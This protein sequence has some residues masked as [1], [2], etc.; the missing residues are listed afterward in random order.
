MY[1]ANRDAADAAQ[2]AAITANKSLVLTQQMFKASQAAA[3]D[4]QMR[5]EAIAKYFLMECV[6]KGQVSATQIIGEAHFTR[7]E[8]KKMVQNERRQLNRSLV[9]KG[10]SFAEI[11]PIGDAPLGGYDWEWMSEQHITADI[12]FSYNNGVERTTQFE[13][14]GWIAR[15]RNSGFTDCDNA[16]A[17][18]AEDHR[19]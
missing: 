14:W 8:V 10:S 3:F 2:S 17:I 6:N 1:K 7:Y 5:Y 15:D 19:P 16:K 9:M 18:N 12:S 13:C 4:C 11:F